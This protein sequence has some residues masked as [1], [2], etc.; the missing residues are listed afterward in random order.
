MQILSSITRHFLRRDREQH[1]GQGI[2]EFALAVPIVLTMLWGVI[3]AG[4]LLFIYSSVASASR[5]AARYAATVDQFNDCAGIRDAAKRLAFFA[6]V[7]DDTIDIEYD[8]PI[9]EVWPAP[10]PYADGCPASAVNLGDRVRV[11]GP[12]GIRSHSCHW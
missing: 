6:G 5:E 11:S 1:R 12:C 4:R 2:V 9:P 8:R 7:S 3:E 10:T